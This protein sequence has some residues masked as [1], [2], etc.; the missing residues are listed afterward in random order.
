MSECADR[1]KTIRGATMMCH[2]SAGSQ[3]FVSQAEEQSK[4]LVLPSLVAIYE[5]I[6]QQKPEQI[7]TGFLILWKEK[8]VL[9]TAKHVLC[10]HGNGND[11]SEK[12][13]FENGDFIPIS[14]VGNAS[15]VNADLAAVGVD[16]ISSKPC[17]SADTIDCDADT[18]GVL[19]ILGY[20]SDDFRGTG[21][22]LS[23]Q[24]CGLY[25]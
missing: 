11:T 14:N 17:L 23:P 7:G 2:S 4:L 8:P 10:G 6:A 15:M 13:L 5:M 20:R 22:T 25:L 12:L 1:T 16:N 18:T 3:T 21:Q 19:T 9:I 24:P